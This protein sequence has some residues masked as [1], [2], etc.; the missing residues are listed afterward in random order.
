MLHPWICAE[1]SSYING[2][3]I[4]DVNKP[5]FRWITA[6]YAFAGAESMMDGGGDAKFELA[7]DAGFF[8][9]RQ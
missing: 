3:H 6:A 5:L 4:N 2:N 9:T 7:S 1:R 8:I